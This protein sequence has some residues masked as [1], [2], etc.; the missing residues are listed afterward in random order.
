MEI[1]ELGIPDAYEVAPQ[2]HQDERGVFLEWY[3]FDKLQDLRGH[4]FEL[5]QANCSVSASGVIRGIHSATVPPGQAK[6]VTCLSGAVLDV[7][8]DIRVGSPTFCRW[9]AVRLDDVDRRAV[10]VAEGL[11]HA[12]MALTN[13][14]TVAYLCSE[15]YSPSREF[16]IDPL[17]P[18]IGIDWPTG[19]RQALSP[20]DEA[21]PS[22]ARG[23][24]RRPVARLRALPG[25]L[26]GL[27]QRVERLSERRPP[28]GSGASPARA[29]A[30]WSSTEY[31]GRGAGRGNRSLVVG[32][33]RSGSAPS[34]SNTA[35]ASP[36]QV[37]AP[38]AVPW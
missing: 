10:Y 19:G 12:F 20:K 38:V 29:H 7:V 13:G 4:G 16:G 27:A 9:E 25:V 2:L 6:Y 24:R 8:V 18:E 28:R 17:D 5:R 1:R 33:T 3:R 11:G 21:A 22:L 36:Y 14:A 15:V 23:S 32:R 26:R 31:A 34:S 37:V 35:R 30:S